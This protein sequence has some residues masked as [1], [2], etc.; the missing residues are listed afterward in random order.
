MSDVTVRD[1][2]Q[3]ATAL[4]RELAHSLLSGLAICGIGWM[5][6]GELRYRSS[7]RAL[8]FRGLLSGKAAVLS[9]VVRAVSEASSPG[10]GD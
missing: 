10:P 5:R 9:F 6:A 4:L 3:C 2:W 8:V 1:E 7:C